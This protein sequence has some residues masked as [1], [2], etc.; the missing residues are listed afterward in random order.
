MTVLRKLN[1]TQVKKGT[2]RESLTGMNAMVISSQKATDAPF[3]CSHPEES[4]QKRS[5]WRETLKA[6]GTK[7]S[8]H[9]EGPMDAG[10]RNRTCAWG[11]GDTWLPVWGTWLHALTPVKEIH[12]KA[13]GLEMEI[14]M[15]GFKEEERVRDHQDV[16]QSFAQICKQHWR[17]RITVKWENGPLTCN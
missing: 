15:D 7:C 11:K 12:L 13:I 5:S 9:V 3:H 10:K 6:E 4:L 16:H 2:E 8:E 14:Y 1:W 17:L